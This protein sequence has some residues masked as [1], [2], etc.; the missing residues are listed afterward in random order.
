RHV[1]FAGSKP[2]SFKKASVADWSVGDAHRRPRIALYSHDTQGLGHIRRNLLVARAL[3]ARGEAPVILLLSGV[4]E[5]AAFSM[6]PG[7]DCVT[8]A[9]LGTGVDGRDFPRSLVV[10]M[11][12]LLK[13]RRSRLMAVL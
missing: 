2:T 10:P 9:S 3:C 12:D 7:V 4:R 8:L 13:V 1:G 11:A 5:A 6:P